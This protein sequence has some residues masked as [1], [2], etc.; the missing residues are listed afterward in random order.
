MALIREESRFH[1]DALSIR[2]AVGLMQ[3]MPSTADWI[4]KRDVTSEELTRPSVNIRAGVSYLSYLENR[5]DTIEQV[6]AAYNGGP[7]NVRRWIREGVVSIQAERFVE[8]IPFP[9]TRA[10]VKR[11]LTS[12]RLYRELY[13]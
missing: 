2:G 1:R 6:L 10:Y 8:E 9:E 12:F 7:T 11:V 5:F 13:G 4:L 3:L